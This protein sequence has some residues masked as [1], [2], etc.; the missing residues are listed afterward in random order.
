MYKPK[1]LVNDPCG[2]D[3]VFAAD[4]GGNPCSKC[5]VLGSDSCFR[6]PCF[7]VLRPEGAAVYYVTG[8]GPSVTPER[9][10]L[11]AAPLLFIAVTSAVV[12]G[13]YLAAI[14]GV[15]LRDAAAEVN[16]VVCPGCGAPAETKG[17]GNA[18]VNTR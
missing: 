1:R 7:S 8:G 11:R 3:P 15:R 18:A 9:P 2:Y 4:C 12:S 16:P 10:V 13:M 6:A 5:G 17:T 14:T